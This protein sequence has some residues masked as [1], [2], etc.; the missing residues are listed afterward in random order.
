MTVSS[1]SSVYPQCQGQGLPPGLTACWFSYML[2]FCSGVW[3]Y[4]ES[5]RRPL[6]L[7]ANQSI[8][9][10]NHIF[11]FAT[12]YKKKKKN[13]FDEWPTVSLPRMKLKCV[14]KMHALEIRDLR[15]RVERNFHE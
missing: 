11:S 14:S 6:E 13:C 7:S 8:S 1:F 3:G 5:V 4:G 12:I 15:N 10:C 9:I 2:F